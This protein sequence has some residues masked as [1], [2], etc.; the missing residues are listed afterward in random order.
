MNISNTKMYVRGF[1]IIILKQLYSVVIMAVHNSI[2]AKE[3]KDI[4]FKD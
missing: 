2:L 4:V 3:E 1:E